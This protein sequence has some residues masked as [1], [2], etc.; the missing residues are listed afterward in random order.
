[1]KTKKLLFYLLAGVL[2]GC[3]PV[4]S[5][6]PL[7]TK[8]KEEVV[9]ESKLL[10]TWVDDSNSI[11]DFKQADANENAYKLTFTDKEGKKGSF[12]AHLVKLK[13]RLFLD[14]YPSEPPWDEE[15]PNKVEWLHNTFFF[16]PVHTFIK[17]NGVEPELKLQITDDDEFK[18]LLKEDPNA[19]EH[20]SIEGKLV[21]T[22]STKELQ[23]FVLKY[24]DD[25]RVFTAEGALNRKKT[26]AP[27]ESAEQKPNEPNDIALNRG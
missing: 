21:L 16:I 23:A 12:V 4:M 24:A 3:L 15:D 25:S 18:K 17:V 20:T 11:W 5:L 26:K 13:N 2:G 6:H 7:F 14:V 22:A 8:E 9:F 19:V 1:M 10:G 27:Q